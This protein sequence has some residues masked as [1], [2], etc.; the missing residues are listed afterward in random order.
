MK[1]YMIIE[2]L[3]GRCIVEAES[4][5]QALSKFREDISSGKIKFSD[6][7]LASADS[8][9]YAVRIPECRTACDWK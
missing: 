4:Q 7:N 1:K 9:E 6:M 2:P 5:A 3:L 8:Q